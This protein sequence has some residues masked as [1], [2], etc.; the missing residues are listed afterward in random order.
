[1]LFWLQ[2]PIKAPGNVTEPYFFL[3]I[4]MKSAHD[5]FIKTNQA[6]ANPPTPTTTTE[7]ITMPAIAPPLNP[8]FSAFAGVVDVSTG[9]SFQEALIVDHTLIVTDSPA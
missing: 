9:I 3:N 6:R 8:F 7:P 1:M 4:A 5:F 2:T